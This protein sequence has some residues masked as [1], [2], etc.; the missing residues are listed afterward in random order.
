VAQ[1]RLGVWLRALLPLRS[2][3]KI[4]CFFLA[5]L[6]LI[7]AFARCLRLNGRDVSW[8]ALAAV[9]EAL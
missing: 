3:S 8:L 5:L 6:A 4:R 7:R 9:M 2:G 1:A